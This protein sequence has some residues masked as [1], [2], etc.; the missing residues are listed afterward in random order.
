MTTRPSVTT[1]I[2]AAREYL[3]RGWYPVPIPPGL[4]RAV[5]KDW[6]S[7]RLQEAGLPKYFKADSNIG[8]ILGEPSGWLVDVDLDCEEAVELADQYLPSTAAI[9]GRPGAPR[10]HRW[11]IAKDAKTQKHI[12]SNTKKMIVELRSTGTQTVVGPSIHPDD[13]DRYDVLTGEPAEVPAAMLSACVAALATAVEERRYGTA[14]TPQKNVALDVEPR[15]YS[16]DLD[17]E[18]R[19]IAYLDKMSPAISGQAGH[20]ATYTAATALVHGFGIPP[21]R[22]LAILLNHYNPRCEPPWNNKELQHKVKEAANKPH[23]RPFCWLRDAERERPMPEEHPGVDISGIVAPSSLHAKKPQDSPTTTVAQDPGAISE[24][25]LRIPGFISEVMDYTLEI[26]P[27]P[28]PMLAFCGALSL[29]AFLGGR[30]VRDQA[31][32]RT[33]LYLLGL[34]YSAVGKDAPRKVNARMLNQIGLAHCLGDGFASGEGIQDLMYTSPNM[35]FQTDEIDGLLQTINKAKDSRHEYIM[36]TLLR[37]YSS[38]NGVFSMRPKAGKE[39]HGSIDQPC[40]TI[41]GTAI[42]THY[43]DALSERMLTNGFFSRTIVTESGPRC[44][45]QEPRIRELPVRV[46]EAAKWW[47]EF[48]PTTGNLENFHPEP[49]IVEYTDDAKR[50]LIDGRIACEAEYAKSEQNRDSVGTTV[51]G[52]V[53]ENSRKLALVYAISESLESPCIGARA[54]TWGI[55]FA[56][57]QARRML[58][59]V[60]NRVADN[61]FETECLKFMQKLRDAPNQTLPHSVALKRMKIDARRF[62]EMVT[63]LEQ[64]G[65]IGTVIAPTAGRPVRTYRLIDEGEKRP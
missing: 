4:K 44:P 41:F 46:L 64:R 15:T 30:K 10:S 18:A 58:F 34:A 51:W 14:I 43:Y 35:F 59:Q 12:D 55:E 50:L 33:N 25:M 42:P 8:L 39:H 28:N 45:G 2:D 61:S 27:Y 9:T 36:S 11:Y 57:H 19:A 52:R 21:E 54:A 37:M 22:A 48:Q 16:T 20:N 47:N 31:D 49:V 32:N 26:A 7:L 23:S 40:L 29:Q 13:H 17:V 62:M 38:A 5:L 6:P 63:T 56:T 65:D 24:S 3:A 53:N 60:Q 1:P